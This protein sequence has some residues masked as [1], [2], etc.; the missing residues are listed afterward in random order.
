MYYIR[1]CVQ[2]WF[3]FCG[4]K[5]I[6]NPFFS[7]TYSFHSNEIHFTI[8]VYPTV[9]TMEYKV[10]AFHIFYIIKRFFF[11]YTLPVRSSL[12]NPHKKNKRRGCFFMR[13]I[14]RFRYQ[15]DSTL[16]RWWRPTKSKMMILIVWCDN[17]NWS[18]GVMMMRQWLWCNERWKPKKV[19][20]F[21]F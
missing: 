13:L 18:C 2:I 8:L 6:K 14:P 10:N 20:F 9:G 1:T 19:F 15:D 4:G 17:K 12:L 21:S 11:C 5:W 7:S 3:F 16:M